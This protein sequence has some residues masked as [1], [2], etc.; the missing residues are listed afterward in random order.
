MC[1]CRTWAA[2]GKLAWVEGLGIRIK[3]VLG[4]GGCSSFGFTVLKVQGYF[5]DRDLQF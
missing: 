4:G 3:N 5:G 1:R 2:C